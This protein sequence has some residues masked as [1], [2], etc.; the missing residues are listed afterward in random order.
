MVITLSPCF[1]LGSE[2][3]N[4]PQGSVECLYGFMKRGRVAGWVGAGASVEVGEGWEV[5]QSGVGINSL[6]LHC[7]S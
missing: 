7:L 2:V 5:R 6:S 3:E 1:G 4:R